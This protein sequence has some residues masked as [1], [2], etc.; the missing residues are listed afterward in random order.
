MK[1]IHLNLAARPYRDYR[2]VYA[3]VVVMSLVTAFLLLN[4][5]ETY[6][7]YIRETKSTRSE[8]A[9]IEGQVQEERRKREAAQQRLATLDLNRLDKQTKFVNARL[10]ERAFSWSTLLDELESILAD[11]VRLQS[12][13]PKFEDNGTIFLTMSFR[14]KSSD[15]MITTINRMNGNPRFRNPFP[16]R[17]SFSEGTYS[18][19]LVAQYIPEPPKR[20]EIV[21]TSAK[22]KKRGGRR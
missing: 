5:I 15:G 7:R 14:S 6:Y 20:S 2:P 17:E 13:S 3:V 22:A 11:D 10:T 1:P 12:V 21:R 9:K 18:F 16:S 8:I 4:N 19:D